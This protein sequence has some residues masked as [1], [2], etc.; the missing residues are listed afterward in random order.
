MV[1]S[2]IT[3]ADSNYLYAKITV[4]GKEYKNIRLDNHKGEEVFD[5]KTIKGYNRIKI[6]DDK[7]SYS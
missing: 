2:K 3:L 4:E 7:N 1:F 5:I 6:V